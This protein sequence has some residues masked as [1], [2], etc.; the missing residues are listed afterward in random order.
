MAVPVAVGDVLQV[1]AVAFAN[2]QISVNVLHYRVSAIAGAPDL[3]LMPPPIDAS[4]AAVYKPLMSINANW[5][6][7]GVRRLTPTPTIEFQSI[8]S[9]GAGTNAGDLIPLQMSGIITKQ[10]GQPGRANRGRVYVPFPSETSNGASGEP[11]AA[12]VTAL[13]TLAGILL[14]TQT[15]THGGINSM[16]LFP[17]LKQHGTVHIT[18]ILSARSNGKWAAQHRRGDFG[19]PNILPF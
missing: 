18:D 7:I 8:T 13:N 15:Y 9:A 3:Q 16:T 2:N 19:R 17:V 14:T 12:Y 4:W 6:G 5:R 10:T 1:R 11:T